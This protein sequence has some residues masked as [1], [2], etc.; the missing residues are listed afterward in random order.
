MGTPAQVAERIA[1]LRDLGVRNLMMKLNVGEMD[2]EAVR[3]SI[4]LFGEKVMPKFSDRPADA[5]AT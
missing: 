2:S 1:S 5:S 3:A 4:R